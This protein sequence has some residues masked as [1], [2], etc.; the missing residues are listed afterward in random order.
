[1]G[2]SAKEGSRSRRR[3]VQSIFPSRRERG[4]EKREGDVPPLFEILKVKKVC[5]E[6]RGGGGG[7]V[8]GGGGGGG[9]GKKNM[10]KPVHS[11]K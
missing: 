9:Y 2:L 3:K 10:G 5:K 4:F 6:G 8:G 11:I 1:V 7:G